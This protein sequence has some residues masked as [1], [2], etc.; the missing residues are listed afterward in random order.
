MSAPARPVEFFYTVR[1][2]GLLLRL[3]DKT[4]IEKLKAGSFGTYPDGPVN[5][6][7]EKRPDYRIP[8]SRINAYLDARRVFSETQVA[9][10]IAARTEGELRRKAA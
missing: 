10:G 7:S 8:A 6:G 5:L 2:T 1:E 4:V 9:L 3:H